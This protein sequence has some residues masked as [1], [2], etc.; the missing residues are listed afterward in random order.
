MIIP[1][2]QYISKSYG[3]NTELKEIEQPKSSTQKT[4]K[5]SP[6]ES[7]PRMNNSSS[8]TK[9]QRTNIPTIYGNAPS[10]I[11]RFFVIEPVKRLLAAH[12]GLLWACGWW[13]ENKVLFLAISSACLGAPKK[14]KKNKKKRKKK[15]KTRVM[16]HPV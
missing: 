13:R 5:G 3:T 15:I 1:R 14:K 2:M 6:R 9:M 12:L 4:L 16:R 10:E 11:H 7:S 8:Y